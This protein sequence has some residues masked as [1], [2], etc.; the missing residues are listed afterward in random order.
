MAS[1][2]V[3]YLGRSVLT[4]RFPIIPEQFA[5]GFFVVIQGDDETKRVLST[6]GDRIR[7]RDKDLKHK[8]LGQVSSE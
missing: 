6:V 1:E 8:E 5:F 2:K 4:F 3:T 7:V